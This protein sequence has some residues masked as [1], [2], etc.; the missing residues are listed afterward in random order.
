MHPT[1]GHKYPLHQFQRH[2][3]HVKE[4]TEMQ[5]HHS[6]MR[7]EEGSCLIK[8]WK[9]LI[10][11]MK[12]CRKLPSLQGHQ[13]LSPL[14]PFPT[15]FLLPHSAFSPWQCLCLSSHPICFKTGHLG[16]TSLFFT[17][18]WPPYII[19]Q[20]VRT[21]FLLFIS[22][23]APGKGLRFFCHSP[24]S[25]WLSSAPIAPVPPPYNTTT[26][27]HAQHNLPWSW[28][29]KKVPLKLW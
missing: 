16:P 8:S 14:S 3:P 29:K 12:E 11:S 10:Y 1:P 19:Q 24:Y 28:G 22:K 9:P 6:K 17:S 18:P 4:A 13:I 23:N 27:F 26:F 25:D 5:P 7:T 20:L 15:F 2:G 21:I